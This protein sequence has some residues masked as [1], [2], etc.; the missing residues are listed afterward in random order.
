MFDPPAIRAALAGYAGP[1]LL[2]AG[3]FDVNSPPAAVAELAALV[4]A[5]TLV[6]QPGAGHNPWRDDPARFL[7]TLME[8]S[9]R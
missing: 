6:V 3:E 9:H 4:S 8:W 5:A 1:V 2:L 7:A